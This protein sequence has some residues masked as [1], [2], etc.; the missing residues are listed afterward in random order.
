MTSRVKA[1]RA[2]ALAMD[3]KNNILFAACRNPA[4]MV[5]VNAPDGKV[6]TTLPLAQARMARLSIPT[7]WKHSVP[8]ATAR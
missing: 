4:N 7:R 8:K 1:A 6:I 2:R 3:A 5:M